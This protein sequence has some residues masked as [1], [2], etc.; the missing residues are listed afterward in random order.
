MI[1]KTVKPDKP[2]YQVWAEIEGWDDGLIH[3]DCLV[4]TAESREKAIEI[5]TAWWAEENKTVYEILNQST[6][7]ID[8]ITEDK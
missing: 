2:I 4:V 1:L 5:A 8:L 7:Q 3:E 6:K